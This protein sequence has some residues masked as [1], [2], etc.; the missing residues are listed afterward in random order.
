MLKN[1]ITFT[2][3]VNKD[4]LKDFKTVCNKYYIHYSKLINLLMDYTVKLDK[5]TNVI[6]FLNKELI[7]WTP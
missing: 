6:E 2:V 3:T 4:S 5:D 1:N 7:E